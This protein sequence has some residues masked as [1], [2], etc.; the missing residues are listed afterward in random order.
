MAN[1]A[2]ERP[3]IIAAVDIGGSFTDAVVVDLDHSEVRYGKSATIPDDMAGSVLTALDEAKVD[4]SRMGQLRHGTTVVINTLLERTGV[5]T[6]VVTSRGFRDILETARG[7]RPD[8]FNVRYRR[9]PPLV[10]RSLRFEVDERVR[11]DGTVEVSLNQSEL[12]SL[13]G[14]LREL[15]VEAVGIVFLHG[16]AHIDHEVRAGQALAATL[17]GVF[18]CASHEVSRELR[19]YERTATVAANAYVG[20]IARRYLEEL[21]TRMEVRGFTGNLWVMDSNGGVMTKSAALRRPVSLVESGPAAGVTG[22][23][24]FAGRDGVASCVAFDVGGTTAKCALIEDGEA[25]VTN[26]YWVGGYRTG[27]PVQI[28]TTDMVEVG[29]GG[30]SIVWVDEVGRLLVGPR[31]A[32]AMPGPACYPFG[33]TDAT[34]TDAN[35]HLGRVYPA[36]FLG[37]TLAISPD[38]ARAALDRVA[39]RFG[40]GC[41]DLALGVLAVANLTMASAIK[42]TTLERGKDPADLALIAYGGGGPL[43][44]PTLARELGM[45]TVI[46]PRMPAHFSAVGM[47]TAPLRHDY[48]RSEVSTFSEESWRSALR[49]FRALE[50]DALAEIDASDGCTFARSIEMRYSG[51]EH[52]VEVPV[53]SATDDF[54]AVLARFHDV[55]RARYGYA[56]R[57][58]TVE[59]TNLRLSAYA[60]L[61]GKD[62]L[63]QVENAREHDNPPVAGPVVE[64]ARQ[65]VVFDTPDGR[66]HAADTPVIDRGALTAGMEIT[67]PA[68]I[69]EHASSLPVTPSDVVRVD[70]RL[71]LVLSIGP[72]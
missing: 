37:G 16:Y 59:A 65:R 42:R 47:L 43:H 50:N 3:T 38:R 25:V 28:S 60:D 34:V 39:T 6:A 53:D 9:D 20:P 40:V 5:R 35:V 55:Y 72:S 23:T 30:G 63:A 62:V 66:G 41:D 36:R 71:N 31:S 57:A 67:G 10:P 11:A 2:S 52:A 22:A 4:F 33:G 8:V 48:R 15:A 54:E 14:R 29:A 45:R 17:P 32:G 69:V 24:S 12:D 51:Q 70:E 64:L 49:S 26:T 61:I 21:S 46:V 27:F 56:N 13:A 44:A 1:R 19:E 18:V 7:N 68:L 58:G